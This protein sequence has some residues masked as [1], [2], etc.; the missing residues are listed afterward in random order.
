MTDISRLKQQLDL[1]V[2]LDKLKSVLRRTRIKSAD[3][4]LENSAEHSWQLALMAV[5]LQEYSAEPVDLITVVKMLLI[6]DVVEIDVG[7]TF[8]YDLAGTAVQAEKERL[9]AERIFGMLPP[10]Q[11]EELLGLWLE[12]EA[13]ET[14]ESCF[15]KALDRTMPMLLN[16]HNDGQSWLEHGVRYEQALAV[17]KDK[18]SQGAPQVW[19]YMKTV[20]DDAKAKGWLA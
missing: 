1:I 4:R 18:I 20:L 5:V 15:A 7:D 11:G 19:E 13:M 17:N 14:A 10:D 6:H 12:F 16:H 2:E 9:A 3:G 8:V